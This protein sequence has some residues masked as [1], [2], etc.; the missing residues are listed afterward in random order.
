MFPL[1]LS[2]S[3]VLPPSLAA[4]TARVVLSQDTISWK[5]V[6]LKWLHSLLDYRASLWETMEALFDRYL[7]LTLDFISPA[8]EDG[9]PAM[10]GASSSTVDSNAAATLQPQ[11]LKLTQVQLV[12][13]CCRIFQVL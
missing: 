3:A 6:L 2:D 13:S 7:P 1:Q 11:D 10:T 12:N 5:E 9:G 8:L 4:K